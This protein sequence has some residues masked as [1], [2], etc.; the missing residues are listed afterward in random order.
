[1]SELAVLLLTD[2]IDSV[3]VGEALGDAAAA[4]LWTEHDRVARD[5]IRTWGGREIDKSDG[6]LVLFGTVPDAAAFAGAYHRAIAAL[7]T[8]L[9]ARAAIHV[10][11]VAR[12]EA[13]VD[14]KALGAKPTE[15]DGMAKS[16][17]ARVMGVATGGRTLLTEDAVRAVDRPTDS[18]RP[19]GRWKLK[20]L[21]EP[22]LLFELGGGIPTSEPLADSDKAY[23]VVRQGDVWVPRHEVPNTLPAE[24]DPFVGRRS[25][26]LELQRRLDAGG[27]LISLVGPG[28]I[29][30]TRLAC[31]QGWMSLGDFPGGVWFCDLAA[32]TTIHGLF[33]GV[34]LGVHLPL[35]P[36]DP[37]DQIAAALVGRGRCLVII[38]N[39]E[40]VA[41]FAEQTLGVWLERTRECCFLVTTRRV[42]GIAGEE[43]CEVAALDPTEG[44]ELF[45]RRALAAR[46]D[47]VLGQSDQAAAVRLVQVLDGLPLAIELAAARTRVLS[48]SGMLD[49]MSRRFELLAARGG[50]DHRQ[51]TLRRTV[52]WSWDLL[53]AVEQRALAQLSTFEGSFSL[54][55]AEAVV[56]LHGEADLPWQVDVLQALVD[57]SLVRR[58]GE[59]RFD[60]LISI[61][62]FAAER[63]A[64]NVQAREASSRRHARY[65]ASFDEVQARRGAVTD[66]D[67]FVA[68][69]RHA[70]A[71]RDTATAIALLIVC[72]SA[73]KLV[74]PFRVASEL[75]DA[76]GS[77]LGPDD[78][79]R[80]SVTWV[81]GSTRQVMGNTS[82][83]LALLQL[84][85]AQAEAAADLRIQAFAHCAIGEC[86]FLMRDPTAARQAFEQ[87]AQFAQRIGDDRLNVYVMNSR[88][89][90][91]LR[92]GESEEAERMFSS[93][94]DTARR[95]DDVRWQG[96]ILGNLASIAYQS[97]RLADAAAKYRDAL[98]LSTHAGDYRWAADTACNLGLLL[99]E[100]GQSEEGMVQLQGALVRVRRLGNRQSEAVILCNLGIV[101]E[102]LARQDESIGYFE[103]GAQCAASL[104]DRG[105]ERLSRGYLAVGL[106]RN[107]S[108]RAEDE[109][110]EA[111][112]DR[113]KGT[114]V[115][116]AAVLAAQAAE[117]AV[118]RGS[119]LAIRQLEIAEAGV[120]ALEE[121][122]GNPYALE[123]RAAL[124]R[125]KAARNELARRPA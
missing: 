100:M 37:V 104:G 17:A 27:R 90:F 72:W 29:G 123:A 6:F 4:R 24:R 119:A 30:K 11:H 121:A 114:D 44:L 84:A 118:R 108:D 83:A 65:F 41:T 68:A 124:A 91:R 111:L 7:T 38:D 54:A 5:L 1:V 46:A 21:A 33:H 99:H 86:R 23:A 60:M 82:E 55:G 110:T 115:G 49:R 78:P 52:E 61:R 35:G 107:G 39:F 89:G 97:G 19:I 50:R 94:L 81:A 36:A 64:K 77:T 101:S 74:G 106:S 9:R 28:G 63:L 66:L 3:Q 92:I 87:A 93:A 73:L 71:S 18:H 20:G 57:K 69:C 34:A 12:R 15:L 76:L 8:P 122:R 16:V 105:L 109:M 58:V 102:A 59:D 98:E 40:Q 112:D 42:L 45:R 116:L 51:A 26:M 96:G 85:L 10:G 31:R 48:V 2:V 95:F 22:L 117:I 62:E 56:E 25:A 67:N 80:A 13:S 125:A 120:R 103:S 53:E 113:D 47:F 79:G 32:A 88:A 70:T 43:V 75:A 14:D